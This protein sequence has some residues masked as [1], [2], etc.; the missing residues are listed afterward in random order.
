MMDAK[1]I[2]A[3]LVIEGRTTSSV[4]MRTMVK[5]AKT[6]NTTMIER[7]DDGHQVDE[8]NRDGQKNDGIRN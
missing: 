5:S 1:K 3:I 6:E 4:M 8:R 7:K 2:S